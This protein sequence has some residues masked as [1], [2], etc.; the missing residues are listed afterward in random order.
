MAKNMMGLAPG[1]ITTLSPDTDIPRV[2]A[3]SS[4][5]RA[6]TSGSPGDGA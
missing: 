6:R 2:V 3:T 1:V 4:A 5:I